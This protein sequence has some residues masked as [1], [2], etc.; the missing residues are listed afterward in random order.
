MEDILKSMDILMEDLS[1]E[2]LE[3]LKKLSTTISDPNNMSVNQAMQIVNEL[4]LDIEKLL[5]NARKIRAEMYMKN[6]KPKIPVNE[7]CPCGSGKKYKKCC[8]WEDQ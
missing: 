3:G 8:I 4:G 7:K 5:K 2:Q 6:K 1:P